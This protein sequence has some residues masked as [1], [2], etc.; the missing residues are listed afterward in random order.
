MQP[1][2]FIR[3]ATFYNDPREGRTFRNTIEAFPSSYEYACSVE[4]VVKPFP[5]RLLGGV[6]LAL[7]GSIIFFL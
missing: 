1:T 6:V 7:I 5:Y 4:R 3:H 2:N